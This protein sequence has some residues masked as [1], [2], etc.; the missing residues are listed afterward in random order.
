MNEKAP[1]QLL[2]KAGPDIQYPCVWL[3]KIIG[4]DRTAMRA[5]PAEQLSDAPCSL[6]D[7]RSSSNGKYISMN[8]QMNVHSDAQ[9]VDLYTR[10]AEHP[11]VTMVL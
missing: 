1:Q 9:R 8:L 6:S 4:T 7:S 10:L 5:I 2:K 11:A 3:Y